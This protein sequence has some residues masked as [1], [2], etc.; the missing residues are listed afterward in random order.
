M[1][2]PDR[3]RDRGNPSVMFSDEGTDEELIHFFRTREKPGYRDPIAAVVGSEV[4]SGLNV[5]KRL[6][7]ALRHV[8]RQGTIFRFLPPRPS[9]SR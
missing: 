7:E 4:K 8:P 9:S 1:G 2:G 3:E 5:A 6:G